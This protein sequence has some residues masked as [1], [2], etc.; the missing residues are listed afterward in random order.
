MD[1]QGEG[2]IIKRGEFDENELVL[3][4]LY[5]LSTVVS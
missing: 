2:S 3:C 5:C 4:I 1:I